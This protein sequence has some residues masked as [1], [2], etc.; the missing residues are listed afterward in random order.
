MWGHRSLTKQTATLSTK[1]L[2]DLLKIL[3]LAPICD[4]RG[5]SSSRRVLYAVACSDPEAEMNSGEHYR[6][7]VLLGT[8]V[9]PEF[10]V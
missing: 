10:E 5:M 1:T 7:G 4:G 3:R 8:V 2:P 6:D 9:P